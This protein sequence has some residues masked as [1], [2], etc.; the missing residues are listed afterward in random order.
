MDFISLDLNSSLCSIQD[1]KR[2]ESE[3]KEGLLRKKVMDSRAQHSITIKG[4][5]GAR[6]E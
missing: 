2:R 1:L 6:E 4:A 3:L 5:A